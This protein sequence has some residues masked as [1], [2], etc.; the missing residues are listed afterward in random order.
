M[1][2]YTSKEEA[3]EIATLKGGDKIFYTNARREGLTHKEAMEISDL[4]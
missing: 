4:Y 1:D 2:A 3:A